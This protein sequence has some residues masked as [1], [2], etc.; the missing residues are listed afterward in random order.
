MSEQETQDSSSEPLKKPYAKPRL[1]EYGPVEK[2]THGGT[3]DH[4]EGGIMM[5]ACL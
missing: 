3:Q 2:L 1:T 5:M 4:G